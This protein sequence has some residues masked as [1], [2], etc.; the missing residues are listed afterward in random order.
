M[1][2]RI[3]DQELTTARQVADQARA[4]GDTDD[5]NGAA[6][7]LATVGIDRDDFYE[8]F[9]DLAFGYVRTGH[10]GVNAMIVTLAVHAFH[11][12]W[13]TAVL[14][15]DQDPDITIPDTLPDDPGGSP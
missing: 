15:A 6:A 7:W 10:P 1:K 14:Y 9:N 3:F 4:S 13:T 12:G 11:I 5:I 8:W 2:P